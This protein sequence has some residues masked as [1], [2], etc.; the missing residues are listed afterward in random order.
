MNVYDRMA[1]TADNVRMDETVAAPLRERLKADDEAV[2]IA[3][4]LMSL[5]RGRHELRI[6][7]TVIDTLLP[8]TQAARGAARL[9]AADAAIRAHDGDLDGALDSCRAVLNVSRSI[10]DEPFLISQLVR[11]AIDALALNAARRVLGQGEPSE[12]ALARLQSLLSDEL[13]QPLFLWAM[14]GERAASSEMLRRI[15]SGGVAGSPL[16]KAAR[17]LPAGTF[18][19]QRALALE[20]MNEAVAIAR[21]PASEQPQLWAAWQASIDRVSHSQFGRLTS[22][23]ALEVIPATSTASLAFARAQCDLGATVI[24]VAAERHRLKTG[25]WPASI[26]AIDRTILPSAP[27]DTFSGQPLGLEHHEGKFV[28]Y[29]IGPNLRDEHGKF[30]QRLWMQGG[31]DDVAAAAWDVPLRGR[32]PDRPEKLG[33]KEKQ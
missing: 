2:Q 30:D 20:W 31:P 26:S 27:L 32:S 6:G 18:D 23:P 3:R 29:S 15:G 13:A 28:V 8:E 9:L 5:S 11:V 19:H 16:S 22:M 10:G 17:F 4:T 7:P 25:K 33:N 12:G 24:L 21:R 1:R 14:K